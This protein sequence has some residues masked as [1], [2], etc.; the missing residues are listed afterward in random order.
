MPASDPPPKYTPPPSYSTA[1]GAR[2]ARM[3][4]QSF[5][6]SVRRLQSSVAPGW[7]PPPAPP[8]DYATVIIESWPRPPAPHH[9]RQHSDPEQLYCGPADAL[10]FEMVPPGRA[11]E[12]GPFS[13]ASGRAEPDLPEFIDFP[14]L[15]RRSVRSSGRLV[16]LGVQRLQRTD[17]EAVLVEA[18]ESI[19]LDSEEERVDVVSVSEDG[20]GPA[21]YVEAGE[22]AERGE[23]EEAV[24]H[25]VMVREARGQVITIHMDTTDSSI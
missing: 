11:G 4:R 22:E 23:V 5:R 3:L 6:R 19:H 9:P 7:K 10:A 15:Q 14:S 1:T 12:P 21:E 25:H 17:S 18:A 20:F 24:N 2:I 16:A 13:L 8:P